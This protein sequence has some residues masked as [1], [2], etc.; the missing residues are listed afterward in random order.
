MTAAVLSRDSGRAG[1]SIR[2][3]QRPAADYKPGLN[4]GSTKHPPFSG[5]ENQRYAEKD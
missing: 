5:R 1:I 3:R 4:A 2:G